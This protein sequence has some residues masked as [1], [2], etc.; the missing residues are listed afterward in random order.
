MFAMLAAQFMLP[1]DGFNE[2]IHCQLV[3][4]ILIVQCPVFVTFVIDVL[5]T[6]DGL[7]T[8]VIGASQGSF[9]G[10]TVSLHG[11]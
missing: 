2:V 7:R 11:M 9:G 5:Y 6:A 1:L 10:A 4:Y 8:F 3:I